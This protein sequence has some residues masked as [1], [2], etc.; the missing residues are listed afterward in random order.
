MPEA[1]VFA[2][3]KFS[4]SDLQS[5]AKQANITIDPAADLDTLA[6]QL[7][8]V[9]TNHALWEMSQDAGANRSDVSEWARAVQ[10]WADEG[11]ILV[12]GASDQA[13]WRVGASA[14][15]RH[16]V[17]NVHHDEEGRRATIGLLRPLSDGLGCPVDETSARAALQQLLQRFPPGLDVL[18]TLATSNAEASIPFPTKRHDSERI[19]LFRHLHELFE[20]LHLSAR[21]TVSTATYTNERH[22]EG[23]RYGSSLDWCRAVFEAAPK[24]ITPMAAKEGELVPCEKRPGTPGTPAIEE[25][26]HT[27]GGEDPHGLKRVFED[28]KVWSSKTDALAERIRA[29]AR[30]R[31]R[32]CAG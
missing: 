10:R 1:T 14:A 20:R 24:R 28:L 9:L 16:L 19:A 27:C 30:R 13:G 15:F 7:S 18:R 23:E 29:S 12:G 11:L 26:R 31:S 3:V 8:N 21:F 6:L 22:K 17:S 4:A 32:N 25:E 5:F 2:T